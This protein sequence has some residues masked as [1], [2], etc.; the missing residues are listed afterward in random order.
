MRYVF[1]LT[2]KAALSQRLCGIQAAQAARLL[3][4]GFAVPRGFVLSVPAVRRVIGRDLI[5]SLRS[6]GNISEEALKRLRD[7]I[8]ERPHPRRLQRQLVSAYRS[9]GVPVTARLSVHHE[10]LPPAL[11]GQIPDTVLEAKNETALIRAVNSHLAS[12]FNEALIR[13]MREASI[14]A[15]GRKRLA[16][17]PAVLVQRA[18]AAEI[19]GVAY[20]ADPASGADRVLIEART[21]PAKRSGAGQTDPACYQVYPDG[22]VGEPSGGASSDQLPSELLRE[23]AEL[24][25]L[26]ADHNGFPQEIEWAW[27]RTRVYIL[28]SRPI[29]SLQGKRI[30]SSAVVSDMLPGLIKPLVWSI[31]ARGKLEATLGRVFT[32]LIGPNDIDFTRLAR[33]IHSRMYADNTLLS[34]LCQ[35]MGLPPNFFEMMSGGEGAKRRPGLR[36]NKNTLA[37][38]LRLIRFLLRRGRAASSLTRSI[39]AHETRMLHYDQI[40]WSSLSVDELLSC[41]EQLLEEYSETMWINFIGPMNM[42]VRARILTAFVNRHVPGVDPWDLITG[43]VG[44]KSLDSNREVGILAV[45]AGDLDRSVLDLMS[46]ENDPVIRESL[47]SV[48]GGKRLIEGVDRFLRKYGFLSS[49]GTDVSRPSWEEVPQ[50]VWSAVARRAL[51]TDEVQ[52]QRGKSETAGAIFRRNQARETVKAKLRGIRRLV[53]HRLLR[54]TIRYINLRERSSVLVSTDSY[55]LRK[56]LLAI[57][58]ERVKAG[59]LTSTEDIFYLFLEELHGLVAG[60]LGGEEARAK[61]TKRKAEMDADRAV[62]PPPILYGEPEDRNPIVDVQEQDFLSGITG[63]SGRIE[64][65]ARI[66]LSPMQAPADLQ[67]ADILIVPFTDA[68]WTIL[69]S[70]IGGLVAET[71]GQLCHTAI[72]AREYGLPALVSVKNATRLIQDGERI[73]LDADQGRVYLRQEGD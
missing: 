72:I 69:L 12:I 52:E 24:T 38:L 10:T 16:V 2:E 14:D 56:A 28:H 49:V 57:A 65:R 42:M 18:I 29:R 15:P 64:G 68:S 23:V 19:S 61:I 5:E 22:T 9:L 25:R 21:K 33:R 26:V 27:N 67:T 17:F 48:P 41:L 43:L 39:A 8:T 34:E 47:A 35:R 54:S 40:E 37:F 46:R 59:E 20:S 73:V 66:V 50:V 45:A 53:F 6:Q 51:R 55:H 36:L 3:L 44:L 32:E 30:Y 1:D 31:S 71:G 60:T 70:G 58:A 13:S 63:S 62:Q 7:R 4:R 11:S